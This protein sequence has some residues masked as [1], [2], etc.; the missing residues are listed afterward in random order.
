MPHRGQHQHLVYPWISLSS[1]ILAMKLI[2]GCLLAAALLGCLAD[3]QFTW[4]KQQNQ[5]QQNKPP[6]NPPQTP[7]FQHQQSSTSKKVPPRDPEPPKERFHICEVEAQYR[8]QCGAAGISASECEAINCCFD[9]RM[10]YYGKHGEYNK[11]YRYC[12]Y[13]WSLSNT[14]LTGACFAICC[15]Q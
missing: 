10:C 2:C 4:Q 11:P 14:G 6:S 13:L 12:N 15:S 1:E 8:I 3:A 7:N 5:Q 9:G